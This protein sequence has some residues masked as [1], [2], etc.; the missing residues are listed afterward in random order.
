MAIFLHCFVSNGKGFDS[1]NRKYAAGRAYALGKVCFCLSGSRGHAELG[2]AGFTRLE[3][4]GEVLD[5]QT[6]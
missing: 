5:R 2:L 1:L 4:L 6:E 3:R